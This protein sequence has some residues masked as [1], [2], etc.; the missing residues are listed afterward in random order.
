M[1]TLMRWEKASRR[2]EKS[3]EGVR[4]VEAKTQSMIAG[5]AADGT[6]RKLSVSE[7]AMVAAE[8]RSEEDDMLR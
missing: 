7:A 3:E 4:P 5:T 2:E 6:R 1:V 8:S